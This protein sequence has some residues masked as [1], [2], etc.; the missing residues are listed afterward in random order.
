MTQLAVTGLSKAFGGRP[1]LTDVDL[2]VPEGS[3][4][5]ILGP[6]GSGKTTLL[7][8]IVGFEHADGGRVT[9]G[10]GFG[11]NTD[12]LADHG[13][14][15]GRRRDVL[16]EYLA[17]MES[18]WSAEEASF[19]GEFVRFDASWAWP[20]TVSQPRPPVLVGAI[21]GP[22]TLEWIAASADGWI[23]TPGEEGIGEKVAALRAAWQAAAR[24]GAPYVVGLGGKPDPA[25]LAAWAEAG[26]DEVLFGM[27]DRSPDEVVAYL[28]RLAAKL[29]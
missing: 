14:P 19:D 12:E 2:D 4:T 3:L 16:R 5:A 21:G 29:A 28:G 8:I 13:V 11:W 15:A 6:S 26:V 10:V 17:G 7:R 25:V 1:V 9:L 22:R 20:K 18:L 24:P 27:P 23:T